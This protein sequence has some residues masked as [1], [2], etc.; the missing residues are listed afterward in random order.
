MRH[1]STAAAERR[2]DPP[3]P[4]SKPDSFFHLSQLLS[5]ES[6]GYVIALDLLASKVKV[7][8]K[9]GG[10]PAAGSIS[11]VPVASFWGKTTYHS[12]TV[13]YGVLGSLRC[14]SASPVQRAKQADPRRRRQTPYAVAPTFLRRPSSTTSSLMLPLLH[15]HPS[16]LAC[17][18][19]TCRVSRRPQPTSATSCSLRPLEMA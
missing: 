13:T 9:T 19:T 12:L 16:R 14:E 8:D 10:A 5:R 1:F 4:S 18:A 6:G 3:S 17:T 7:L 2:A 15:S 11:S